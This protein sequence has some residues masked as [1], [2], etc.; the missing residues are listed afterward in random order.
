MNSII[1]CLLLYNQYLVSQ[2]NYLLSFIAKHIPIKEYIFNDSRSPKYQK[3]KL[4]ILP[5]IVKFEK[6]DYKF[7]IEYYFLSIKHVSNL[8]NVAVVHLL[9]ILLSVPVVMRLTIISMQIMVLLVNLSAKYVT[10]TLINR[11][12]LITL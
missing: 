8:L 12:M 4:D 2:I 3:L 10:R 6:Q 9:M 1:H 7:L 5:V 11:I